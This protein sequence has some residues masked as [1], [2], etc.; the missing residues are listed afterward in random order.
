M[1][2]QMNITHVIDRAERIDAI[3]QAAEKTT[4]PRMKEFWIRTHKK[5]IR[6]LDESRNSRR[7]NA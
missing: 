6:N 5:L 2:N 1:E 7:W 4:D 3:N